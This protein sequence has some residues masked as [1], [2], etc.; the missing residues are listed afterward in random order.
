[1]KTVYTLIT[2]TDDSSAIDVFS[3]YKKAKETLIERANTQCT[4]EAPNAQILYTYEY[5][6]DM[7]P[8]LPVQ[9]RYTKPLFLIRTLS[10][11]G[12]HTTFR[13]IIES[14]VDQD[15]HEPM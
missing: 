14:I 9:W 7:H 10:G 4:I 11:D 8:F 6:P 5:T 15:S 2:A 3:S 12:I 1:M 13:F